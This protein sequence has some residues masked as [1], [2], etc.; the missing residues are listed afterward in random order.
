MTK[1]FKILLLDIHQKPMKE[2]K[3]ALSNTLENWQGE[4]FEQI[5][6][7]LVIGVRV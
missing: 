3:E 7:V 4:N 1:R 6:D 2:Q 5:D